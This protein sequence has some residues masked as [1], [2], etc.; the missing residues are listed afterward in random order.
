M[1]VLYIIST[2]RR[3]GPTNLLYDVINHL[4]TDEFEVTVLTLSPERG[5]SSRWNDFEA[6]NGVKVISLNSTSKSIYTTGSKVVEICKELNPAVVHVQGF[7]PDIIAS[8]FLKKYKCV[9]NIQ[10]YPYDDYVMQF[11]FKGYL[12]AFLSLAFIRN[13]KY[14]TVCSKYVASKIEKN[15][16]YKIH[17]VQNAVEEGFRALSEFEINNLRNELGFTPEHKVLVFAG[18]LIKR[19]NPLLLINAFNLLYSTNKNIKLLVLGDG[20]LMSACLQQKKHENIILIGNVEDV[21]KY[22]QVSDYYITASL[23]EGMPVSVLEALNHGLPVILSD[24]PQHTEIAASTGCAAT[25]FEKNNPIDLAEKILKFVGQN[26]ENQTF[27]ASNSIKQL[28]NAKRMSN[29]FQ[30]LYRSTL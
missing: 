14:V 3:C 23:S 20:Y 29:Q 28:F 15:F 5:V 2:L 17:I 11:G 7:R 4:P 1:K 30:N 21:S 13:S 25:V 12:M 16:N 19:K 26:Y 8:L 6:I 22:Y 10:N 24:I 18:N 9:Y 27:D